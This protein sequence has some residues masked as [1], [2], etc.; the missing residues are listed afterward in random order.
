M[1][2]VVMA[3]GEGSRLRPVTA[4]RPKPMVPICNQPIME[5]ILTLLKRHGITEV[6][7]TLY[8]LADEIQSY[9]G[10]GSDFGVKMHYSVEN[11]PL[12]TAGS[13]KKAEALLN[14]GPFVIVS[15]DALT[16]CDLTKALEFHRSKKS[17]ATLILY[18]V[19]SP[20]E[21]GVVI[22]DDDGRV[23]RFLEKPSWSEVFSDTVN[24]GMYILEPEIFRFMEENH[25]YDWSSDIFP[26]LLQERLPMYGYVMEEYWT[27]VGS[28]GQ[29]REAQEDLL[30][31]R[32]DLPILGRESV[33]GVHI[34]PNTVVDDT[35]TL[36][37]PIC[38]GRNVKVKKG[39][40][41]G[42]Y[43][44]VGD[45]AF[46]EEGANVERSI[47]WDSAYIG[48]NVGVHS[49]IVCS[50]ATVKRD[51][52]VREDAVIG[53]RCLVDVGCNIRPRVKLWPDKIVER[54]STVTMSLVWGNKW[55]GNLF[56]ELGA[57]GLS[58]IEITPDFACRLGSA[59]GSLFPQGSRIITFR[60][61]TRSSRMIK[62]ALI[63]SLLSVGCDVLDMRSAALPIARH[64]VKTSGAA[65][66]LGVRKLPGNSRVTLIEML[67][68]RG[69]YLSR[70]ME[71]KVEN[72]FF[73][74]DFKR[75]DPD[76]LGIMEFVSRAVEEYQADYFRLL[77]PEPAGRRL[78]VVCDYGYSSL[79]GI[80]PAMIAQLGIESIS[81]NG[82]ND[83]KLA[84][85]TGEEVD[86]HV[87][88]LSQI[89]GTLGYDMGV[90]F[91]EEGERL[92]IV[93]ERGEQVHGNTLLAT[94]GTLIAKTVPSAKIAI[95][96]TAPTLLEEALK[97][98]GA[99]VVRTKSDVRSLMDSSLTG[100]ATF[101]GDERG[102]FIFPELHPGF[103]AAFSFG[104]LAVML[105]RTGLSIREVSAELP[106][107]KLAYEQV[108]V[109]WDAKGSVMR[110]ISEE[111][112][113][114]RHVEL[115]DG[116]KI[117]EDDS[118]VLVLPDAV[119]PVFHVYA[120]SPEEEESRELVGRY[121]RK[122]EKLMQP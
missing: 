64:F 46:I 37:P 115:L 20:L 33:K 41:I 110:R 95:S 13:V 97:K 106:V 119:E 56:R 75:A 73:R 68:S 19:P 76:D 69:A 14:D 108:K 120:E 70:A 101:A 16:D 105:Q 25:N 52:V 21:F 49:A 8:Y 63:S 88:N 87:K 114:G 35:A 96:V 103:D 17:L 107:F 55:R 6:V 26:K 27:D 44:V 15:G 72:A 45:N 24:T 31:G 11:V 71:R 99:E 50:R 65:G 1:K 112:R 34:G 47:V 29:Y 42:P 9:F 3:G 89:V 102:G 57:A 22:T 54:G 4:N 5:H 48:P 28:L 32:V 2:A 117:F 118:W 90:L 7:S 60:D 104:M 18:R 83:A 85:R 51:S 61:S 10:D 74:E 12:G 86:R 53:D 66:A 23:V 39:A 59:F 121:I 58:N 94:L 43:A 100:G 62:R 36:V 93:D 84:P 40:R 78:R 113:D 30:A 91:T 122:I 77:H 109:P 92:T 67:D 81:L 79:S 80:F 111:T 98:E 116:I 82:F 38:L